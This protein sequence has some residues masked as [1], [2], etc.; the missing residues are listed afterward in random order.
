MTNMSRRLP[1]EWENQDAILMAFPHKNSDWADDLQSALSVF[2]RIAS[3]IATY[4]K[5]ILICDDIDFTKKL[6]CYINNIYFVKLETNDTWIRDYGLIS[7]YHNG[8]REL[9]D[10]QF[11]AWGSKFDFKL[12]NKINKKLLKY[13][14]IGRWLSHKNDQ[15][16]NKDSFKFKADKK[17][18]QK[19]LKHRQIGRWSSTK[20]DFILEGGSLESDGSGTLITTSKCLL[21]PNRNPSF[22]K[23]E[24]E[25]M[26]KEF[27]GLSRVLWLNHGELIGDDTD[28]HIDTL[29]R[30]VD[31]ETIVYVS[32]DNREDEHYEEL[33]KMKKELELFKTLNDNPYQL[34]PLPLPSAKYKNDQ[35]LPAT[36]AN[37]LITNRSILLPIY[38]DKHDKEMILLFKGLFPS[39]EIIPINALRLIE[40]GGSIHCSTMHLP[41]IQKKFN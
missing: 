14:Q 21:N 23:K 10:F 41:S 30:F 2:V 35:R 13:R 20:I 36:Y 16:I 9:L 5:L 19:L 27:L 17:I 3:S 6:F 33:K 24:I 31:K 12:D 8:V 28:A 7:I 18:T 26:L 25:N 1:A 34:I 39:R 40:E 32:C 11:N 29:V 37:F 15:K 22:S 4:Q 38:Q